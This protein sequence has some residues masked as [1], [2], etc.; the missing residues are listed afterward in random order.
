MAQTLSQLGHLFVQTIPTV[1]FVFVLFLILERWFFLPV[2]EV[3]KRRE[4][5]TTGALARAREQVATAEAKAKEYE[6]ALQAARQ[7]IYR[8]REAAR[9]ATLEEREDLL[10]K[11]RGQSEVLLREAQATLA[12]EVEGAKRE[13]QKASQAL[14]QEIA[15]VVLEGAPAA[16]PGGAAS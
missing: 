9:R 7:E 8:Q 6:A 4:E 10:K 2:T 3:L 14:G 5:Q 11:A 15:Q 13:L 16:G 12:M 1:L